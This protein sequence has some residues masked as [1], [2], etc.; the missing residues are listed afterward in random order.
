MP[1]ER[2]HFALEQLGQCFLG[3]RREAPSYFLAEIGR[4]AAGVFLGEFE[5]FELKYAEFGVKTFFF[6]WNWQFWKLERYF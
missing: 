2:V 5:G 1:R 3:E 6:R 4:E